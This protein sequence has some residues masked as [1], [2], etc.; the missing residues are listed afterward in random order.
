MGVRG[1]TLKAVLKYL[2]HSTIMAIKEITKSVSVLTFN[3][4]TTENVMKEIKDL[5][6]S[7][8]LCK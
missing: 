4:I 3:H 6:A 7:K 2:N 8:P 1:C 5:D